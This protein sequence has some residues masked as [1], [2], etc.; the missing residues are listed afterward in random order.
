MKVGTTQFLKRTVQTPSE[1][2]LV[3]RKK[4]SRGENDGYI[5]GKKVNFSHKTS[6]GIELYSNFGLLHTVNDMH[7]AAQHWVEFV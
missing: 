6:P 7:E 4:K 1:E 2:F 5:L 3:L